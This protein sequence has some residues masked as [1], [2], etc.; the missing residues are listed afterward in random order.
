MTWF[1]DLYAITGDVWFWH[2]F[3]T[4]CSPPS[5]LPSLPLHCHTCPSLSPS[6]L[7]SLPLHCHTC[8][9]LSPSL[10]P[11]LPLHCHTCPSLSPSLL[12]SLPL[13]RHTCPSLSPSLLPPFFQTVFP[14]SLH[15][16]LSPSIYR[17][18]ALPIP[19]LPSPPSLPPSLSPSPFPLSPYVAWCIY[20]SDP[21][22]DSQQQ[23]S[24][25]PPRD[26]GGNTPEIP[27]CHGGHI[28][29]VTEIS[30]DS[31][32]QYYDVNTYFSVILDFE[33]WF[34]LYSHQRRTFFSAAE[35]LLRIYQNPIHLKGTRWR[36]RLW[37]QR[38]VR[39][40]K[41]VVRQRAPFKCMGFWYIRSRKNARL[42]CE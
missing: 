9:S 26:H 27:M 37:R 14:L 21:R 5:L 3:L 39:R 6:L 35:I 11:S 34:V 20:Y 40:R 30:L 33:H 12:P 22:H 2:I 28:M 41:N 25:A 36:T 24:G 10:L 32:K 8:P 23:R 29:T 42:W 13:H 15:F 19:P 31:W 17:P 7:P 1:S 18:I 38:E 16:T 4:S